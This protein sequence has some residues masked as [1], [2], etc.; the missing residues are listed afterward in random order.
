MAPF[1]GRSDKEREQLLRTI[2]TLEAQ[3]SVLGDS[4]VDLALGPI[5]T[6][7]AEFDGSGAWP[8]PP[9]LRSEHKV[10]TVVY[11]DVSGFTAMSEQLGSEEVRDIVNGLFERLVPIVERYGGVIDKFMGD[12]IMALFGAPRATEHHAD[13]ALRACLDM[14]DEL[15]AFNEEHDR[16]LGLH[17]GVNSGFVVAGGIGSSRRQD[18]SVMGDAVNIAARLKDASEAGEILVGPASYRATA[19]SFEFDALPPIPLKGKGQPLPVYRLLSARQRSART[20]DSFTLAF[21]GRHKELDCLVNAVRSRAPAVTIV[22]QPG[23]GKSR[24]LRELRQELGSRWPWLEVAAMTHR[25]SATYAVLHDLF[26]EI[27]GA[28][29]GADA[30]KVGIALADHLAINMGETAE[31]HGPY[32]RRFRDLPPITGDDG[33]LSGLAP[34]VIRQRLHRAVVA[35]FATVAIGTRTVICIEDL[36][37]ADSSS[38]ELLV[39]IVAKGLMPGATLVVTSRIDASRVDPWL[40][41]VRRSGEERVIELDP[42]D[43][44]AVAAVLDRTLVTPNPQSGLRRALIERSEGNPFYLA[45]FLRSLVDNGSAILED[46]RIFLQREP[47]ELRPPESLHA[48]VA[49]RIDRLDAGAKAVLRQASI[50]GRRFRTEALERLA[51]ATG[52]GMP[53]AVLGT[54]LERQLIEAAGPDH[55]QFVHAVVQDVVYQGMLARERRRLHQTLASL[56]ADEPNTDDAV[57]AWHLEQAGN[58]L[59]ASHRYEQA[60]QRA[61][62]VHA[63]QDALAHLEKAIRLASVSDHARR[64]SLEERAADLMFLIGWFAEAADRFALLAG[65]SS[66]IDAARLC[67]KRAHTLRARQQLDPANEQLAIARA[68]LAGLQPADRTDA[69]WREHFAVEAESLWVLYI[70]GR[71]DEMRTAAGHL[72]PDLEQRGTQDERGVYHRNLALLELRSARM[73]A[74]P[75]TVR[76]AELSALELADG[77]G[78]TFANFGHAFMLLWSGDRAAAERRLL[79]VLDDARR[80]GDAE[81]HLLCLTYL[82]ILARFRHDVESARAFAV[83]GA[84]AARSSGARYYEGIA[85]ANLAWVAWRQGDVGDRVREQLAK[86]KELMSAL[87]GYPFVWIAGFVE[88]AIAAADDDLAQVGQLCSK[89]VDPSQ[90]RL[91]DDLLRPLERVTATPTGETV[92]DLLSAAERAGYL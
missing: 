17:I 20:S 41:S 14:F 46:G 69:W 57:I 37:W 59:E 3:R 11:V 67:R 75:E 33:V 29:P 18:Y 24:L 10:V 28:P 25:S 16:A 74:T 22:S 30:D 88:V 86:A 90:Q 39:D 62:T 56:L 65:Q 48:V 5:R 34:E 19:S 7:L 64:L 51:A 1:A 47:A 73:T 58:E 79:D 61:Q 13:H 80:V 55:L 49:E 89:L 84:A 12:E 68:H 42:L 38:I 9:D 72:A 52:A 76:L 4:A 6:R 26:D 54:L 31:E 87:P 77:P 27:I 81:V 23:L 66:G 78:R 45:S 2:R 63:N 85:T 15:S 53:T 92:A 44:D 50:I 8:D 36:H 70:Q 71:S 35:L 82:T 21:E 32:L 91:P 83:A 40:D 60:A 43:A